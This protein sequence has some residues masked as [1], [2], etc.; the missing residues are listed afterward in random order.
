M[1]ENNSFVFIFEVFRSIY[2][3]ETVSDLEMLQDMVFALK[4][5][6]RLKTPQAQACSPYPITKVLGE[7]ANGNIQKKSR[8]FAQKRASTGKFQLPSNKASGSD[9]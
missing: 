9:D 2:V 1:F 3:D 6:E 5:L 8:Q 4:E 7:I